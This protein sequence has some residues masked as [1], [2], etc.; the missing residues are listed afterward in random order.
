MF[1][2]LAGF[3]DSV[4]IGPAYNS[5]FV[6]AKTEDIRDETVIEEDNY[7]AALIWM[8]SLGVDITTS[9]LG[10]NI[11]NDGF[12]YSYNDMDGRTAV[13]TKALELAFQR[14]VS[15]FLPLEMKEMIRGFI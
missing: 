2:I 9:S 15:T 1:S 12:E 11:F 3:K 4:L 5:S 6:L 14:G 7:A 10:Y 13:T 8:E